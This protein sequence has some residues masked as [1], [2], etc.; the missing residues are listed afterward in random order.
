MEGNNMEE[1]KVDDLVL[2]YEG[3]PTYEDG[4]LG[5]V[6][7]RDISGDWD[8]EPS[9]FVATLEEVYSAEGDIGKLMGQAKWVSQENITKVVFE[10]PEERGTFLES[11]SFHLIW[12][13]GILTFTAGFFIGKI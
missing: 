10:K 6:I 2:I 13:G 4:T 11:Y 3:T 7:D 9:Y 5:K 8:P 12:L 1:Y